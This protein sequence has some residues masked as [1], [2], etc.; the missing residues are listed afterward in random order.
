MWRMGVCWRDGIEMQLHTSAH[1][2]RSR[3]SNVPAA[4]HAETPS[5]G[6][7]ATIS[8]S[9]SFGAAVYSILPPLH[10]LYDKSP[11]MPL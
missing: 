10:A 7:S 3:L 9:I 6:L 2:V 11:C 5:D 4:F 8:P 1:E